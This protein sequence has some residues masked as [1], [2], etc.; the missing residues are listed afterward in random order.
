[1]R[2]IL[3]LLVLFC[4]ISI[5]V[6]AQDSTFSPINPKFIEYQKSKQLEKLFHISDKIYKKG[7]MQPTGYIPAPFAQVSTWVKPST[8]RAVIIPTRYDLR[9]LGRVT[10]VRNQNPW[11]TCWAFAAL[12]SVESAILT[13][14]PF[15]NV[16]FS[17]LHMA[18]TSGF[19]P[20]ADPLETGGHYYMSSAYFTRF[21]GPVLE[22]DNPYAYP[23]TSP[24]WQLPIQSYVENIDFM[25]IGFDTGST[26]ILYNEY[27]NIDYSILD[28]IKETIMEKGAMEASYYY[29]AQYS[30]ETA[31]RAN[32][33]CPV[34][35]TANHSVTIV[36]WDD[37][38]LQSNFRQTP[39]GSGAFLVKN[40]WGTNWGESGYF[41]LSYYD[42]SACDYASY[43]TVAT[44]VTKYDRVYYANYGGQVGAF[45]STTARNVYPIIEDAFVK[46]VG[47]FVIY[48]G[49]DYSLT[50]YVNDIKA[51]TQTGQF[52]YAGYTTIPLSETLN[53]RRGD[54]LTIEM[55]YDTKNVIKPDQYGNG[56]YVIPIETNVYPYYTQGTYVPGRSYAVLDGEWED[57]GGEFYANTSLRALVVTDKT[58]VL[59]ITVTPRN[60]DL[61]ADVKYQFTATIYPDTAINK[62][63]V[64]T[65]SNPSVATVDAY[66][67]VT[68]ITPGTTE[69]KATAVDGNISDFATVNV[70]SVEGVTISPKDIT[71]DLG[72]TRKFESIITPSN[73]VN[74]LVTWSSSNPNVATVDQYGFVTTKAK[75]TT[76]ITIITDDGKFTD[77]SKVTVNSAIIPVAGVTIDPDVLTICSGETVTLSA[78]I[79]PINATNQ[80]VTWESSNR[81]V[82][83]VDDNGVVSALTYGT[84]QITAKSVDGEH[85]GIC[86]LTVINASIPVKVKEIEII[87]NSVTIYNDGSEYQLEAKITP[88]N[89]TNQNVTWTSLNPD[90]CSVSSDGKIKALTSGK[91]ALI[92]VTSEDGNKI[93]TC[94][95]VIRNSEL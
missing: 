71:L 57:L 30:I 58:K 23:W 20:Y 69:I 8:K 36:G 83:T 59:S 21:S 35:Q 3:L 55:N 39:P 63:I 2:R 48:G 73:A 28:A 46:A 94:R 82:A 88:S 62:N 4:T 9:T 49:L 15:T 70:I 66:G 53:V 93:A 47:T 60:I 26:S 29:N 6:Y 5:G 12:A 17:A 18:N 76:Y 74:K 25:P 68:T 34:P 38:Y 24:T 32:F 52:G 90:I 61:P 22:K 79:A 42:M 16:H 95:V 1:M 81:F 40:S 10:P 45:A 65:S 51:I 54:K 44:D 72:V 77:T 91:V 27:G 85:K 89:A 31:T 87:P 50:L 14:T 84:C 75:G 7:D 11:G 80:D 19:Y 92:Q 67:M 78:V 37:N 43:G 56:P 86:S 13:E 41:W 64:W 33:Y